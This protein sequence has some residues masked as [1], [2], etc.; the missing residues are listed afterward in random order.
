[1]NAKDYWNNLYKE[2]LLLCN[3]RTALHGIDLVNKIV[4]TKIYYNICYATKIL[5]FGCGTGELCKCLNIISNNT[6]YLGVDISREAIKDAVSHNIYD[7]IRYKAIDILTSPLKE[8]FDLI[9]TSNTL[10]HFKEPFKVIGKLFEM[11]GKLLIIVP[12]A[13]DEMDNYDE[14][15]G[16]GHASIFT[17]ESFKDYNIIEWFTFFT[18]EWVVGTNPRQLVILIENK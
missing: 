11:S 5:E 3:R 10:E 12:Y 13:Q 1:M 2:K 6:E 4:N 9:I 16:A 17:E 14:E 7:N 18:H 15:G 8:K